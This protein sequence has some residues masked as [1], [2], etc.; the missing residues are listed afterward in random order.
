V[1]VTAALPASVEGFPLAGHSFEDVVGGGIVEVDP[2]PTSLA[3]WHS[4]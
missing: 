4:R 3:A 2:S 1:A